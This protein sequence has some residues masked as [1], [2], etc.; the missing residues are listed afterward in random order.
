METGTLPAASETVLVV[1]D[2]EIVREFVVESL[3][4]FGYEVLEARNG[5]EAL[6]R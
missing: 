5:A 1:E 2:Q 3:R 4:M 6:R